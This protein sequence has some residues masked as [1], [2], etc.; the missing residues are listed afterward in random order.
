[1]SQADSLRNTKSQ[2]CLHIC[3][4]KAL[5]KLCFNAI[6]IYYNNWKFRKWFIEKFLTYKQKQSVTF[7]I[8]N[9]RNKHIRLS[10]DKE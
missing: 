6:I 8:T 2:K 4:K 3:Q 1:M 10:G 7:G 9:R 5:K